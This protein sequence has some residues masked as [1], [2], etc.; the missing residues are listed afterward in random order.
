MSKSKKN[1][2]TK[3][4]GQSAEYQ[5]TI[6]S[7]KYTVRSGDVSIDDIHMAPVDSMK[8]KGN[9]RFHNVHR[10]ML[11]QKPDCGPMTEAQQIEYLQTGTLADYDMEIDHVMREQF[12]TLMDGLRENGEAAEE[13]KVRH[14]GI[15]EEGNRRTA[16]YK[17]LKK[18]IEESGEESAFDF[19]T[20]RVVCYPEDVTPADNRLD[21]TIQHVTQKAKWESVDQVAMLRALRD[22]DRL[23]DEKIAVKIGLTIRKVRKLL[24]A[25]DLMAQYQS[26]TKD[27]RPEVF[28][29]FYKVAA[30]RKLDKIMCVQEGGATDDD[31]YDEGLWPQFKTWVKD[32]K[33]NDCRDVAMFT[34]KDGFLDNVGTL[35]IIERE[36]TTKAIEALKSKKKSSKTD[37]GVEKIKQATAELLSLKPTAKA[38][39]MKNKV[40]L[41]TLRRELS[42]LSA[43]IDS[44]TPSDAAAAAA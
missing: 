34:A 14:N 1:L 41:E 16:A 10:K 18:E 13:L 43:V 37:P 17:L 15:V 35:A 19:K 38:E 39:V 12:I 9:P 28:T 40:L 27:Y 30:N 31:L 25:G 2:Y 5:K 20:V 6:G 32:D 22:Q 29:M 44:L 3:L 23:S 33:I 4:A 24:R 7:N 21:L 42:A 8:G 26:E 36:G 11:A